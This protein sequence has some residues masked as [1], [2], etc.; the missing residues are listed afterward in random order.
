V[1]TKK[2]RKH[3]EKHD[4]RAAL[5]NKLELAKGMKVMV[6]FDVGTNLDMA[7]RAR[8]EITDIVLDEREEYSFK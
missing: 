3:R 8:R 7:N 6:T 1:A 5:P 4:E 2:E